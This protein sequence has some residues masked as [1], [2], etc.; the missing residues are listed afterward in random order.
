MNFPRISFQI[1]KFNAKITTLNVWVGDYLLVRIWAPFIWPGVGVKTTSLMNKLYRPLLIDSAKF[2][3]ELI[4]A[5]AA[6]IECGDD[7]TWQ[8]LNFI[9]VPFCSKYCDT[10]SFPRAI[11][12]DGCV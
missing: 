1:K 12:I 7:V 6:Q 10:N 9:R 3:C 11:K 4:G 2:D 5:P 8:C